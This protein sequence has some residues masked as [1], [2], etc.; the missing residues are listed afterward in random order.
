VAGVTPVE[1]LQ[2]NT[3]VRDNFDA[4]KAGHIVCTSSTRPGSLGVSDEGLMIYETDTKKVFVWNGSAWVETNNLNNA[5][6]VSDATASSFASVMV[7]KNSAT[8]AHNLIDPYIQWD[9]V[10]S[11]YPNTM[12]DISNPTDIVVP[13]SGLYMISAYGEFTSP[14][15]DLEGFRQN[16]FVNGLYSRAIDEYVIY[17]LNSTYYINFNTALL[18]LSAGNTIKT[19]F[20][21]IAATFPWSGAISN[22]SMSVVKV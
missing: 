17:G 16:M 2:W 9:S 21:V 14:D 1:A 7:T 18:P 19:T 20:G 22:L 13:V 5:G 6:G 4:L 8:M 12:W 15:N 3:Y 10:V 11:E